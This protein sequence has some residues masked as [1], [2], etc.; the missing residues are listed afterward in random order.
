MVILMDKNYSEV[1]PKVQT[2][3]FGSIREA[4]RKNG[5]DIDLISD[6]TAYQ[7]LQKLAGDY[8]EDFRNEIFQ[9]GGEILRDDLTV[10]VN[11]TIVSHTGTA[12]IKLKQGDVIALFSIFPGG[13]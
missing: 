6:T 11:G 13:G 5:E 9:G 2:Q 10:T 3:Y 4:A 8:G 1:L 12:G 7:L